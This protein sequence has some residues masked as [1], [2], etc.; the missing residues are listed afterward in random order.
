MGCPTGTA[1]ARGA[2]LCSPGCPAGTYRDGAPSS[3]RCLDCPDG[4]WGGIVADIVDAN[5]RSRRWLEDAFVENLGCTPRTFIF[6]LRIREAQKLL[7]DNPDLQPGEVA[8]RCGYSGTRQLNAHFRSELGM[9]A[10]EF[11]KAEF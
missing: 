9:T 3:P 7:T 6:R 4:T 8:A 10:R 2:L 11:T 1:S 5:P